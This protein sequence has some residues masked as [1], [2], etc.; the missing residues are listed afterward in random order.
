MLS[1]NN[2]VV[3]MWLQQ[4]CAYN[5]RCEK[6][7]GHKTAMQVY[8]HFCLLLIVGLCV[9][10]SSCVVEEIVSTEQIYVDELHSVIQVWTSTLCTLHYL[11]AGL[12]VA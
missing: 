1:N 11:N 8:F 4:W 2:K 6:I 5:W 3:I 9:C 12:V 7:S 10:L